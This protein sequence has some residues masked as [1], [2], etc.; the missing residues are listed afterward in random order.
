[1]SD[2]LKNLI[3]AATDIAPLIVPGAGPL[4]KVGKGIVDALEAAK[5]VAKPGDQS[6]IDQT[7]DQLRDK[8]NAHFDATIAG[9]RGQS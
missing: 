2:F 4:I 8:V 3:A 1:M 7:L 9:L 6:E 5:D